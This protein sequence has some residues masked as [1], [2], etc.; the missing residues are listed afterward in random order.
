[1]LLKDIPWELS[2]F[3]DYAWKIPG[4]IYVITRSVESRRYDILTDL[5]FQLN[6]LLGGADPADGGM[7]AAWPDLDAASAQAVLFQLL[8]DADTARTRATTEKVMPITSL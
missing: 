3:G 8:L 5:D 6:E 1:M 2:G 7:A 4:T